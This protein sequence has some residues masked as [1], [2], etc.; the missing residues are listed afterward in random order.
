MEMEMETGVS[1]GWTQGRYYSLLSPLQAFYH[2][3]LSG[4]GNEGGRQTVM[5]SKRS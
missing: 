3:L 1:K 2:R 5:K 4:P